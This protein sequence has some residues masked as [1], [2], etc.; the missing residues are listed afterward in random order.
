MLGK[1]F[2]TFSRTTCHLSEYFINCITSIAKF[3]G[4]FFWYTCYPFAI[5]C[6]HRFTQCA[7]Q[8]TEFADLFS[9]SNILA[10][11]QNFRVH[12]E[13]VHS[14]SYICGGWQEMEVGQYL[15]S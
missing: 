2:C 3:K 10:A 14:A 13:K 9:F 6:R 4:F 7:K 11:P 1:V 12:C 5:S 8:C 15:H